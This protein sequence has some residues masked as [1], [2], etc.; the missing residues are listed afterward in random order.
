MTAQNKINYVIA[1]FVAIALAGISASLNL[2]NFADDLVFSHALDN[3]SLYDFMVG[4]Y[5]G[6]SGR[7]TL[8]ALM[9]GTINYHAV[10]KVGIPLSIILLCSSASRII[11]GKF[12][13]KVT[14]L[15]VF[16]YLLLPKE[17]LANGSWWITGFYNYLLPA[18]A[19][20]Y[21]LSVFM[22]RGAVGWTEGALSLLCL[23]I[24]CFSEQT[25]IVT[26]VSALLLI[27]FCRDFRRPF[28]YAYILVTAV[29]SWLMFSAPG[30]FHRLQEETW[31]WMPG[32]ESESLVNKL[33]YGYDRIHQ[34]MV[35][36]DSI[37]FCLLCILCIILIIKDKN[38]TKVGSVFALVMM[39]HVALMLLIRLGL[40]H[41]SESFYN[42]EYLNP[43]RWISISRYCSYLFTGFVILGTCY[44]LAVAAL[45]D[46]DFV[47]PLVMIILGFA[48]ILMVGFSPTVYASGMRVLY[49]WAVMIMCSSCF[50]FYK[51]YGHEKEILRNV[52]ACI[53]AAYIISI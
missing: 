5:A 45:K 47:K 14:A 17:I 30:N 18:A 31:R 36:P 35:M 27:F 52:V 37:V 44:A 7:F 3:T 12:D 22:K 2:Q 46:R 26:A 15:S 29:L 4:S 43:Q 19:M 50:I 24:S 21:S 20:L 51:I 53:I 6:W 34:A 38:R 11:T 42:P 8:N 13:L 40:L 39:A 23:T 16:I 10:W 49:L 25:S 28:S 1:F 33:I 9:V 41:P 32:Y 48:T